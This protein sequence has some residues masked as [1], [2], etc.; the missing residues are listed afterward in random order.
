MKFCLALLILGATISLA[1]AQTAPQPATGDAITVS[2]GLSPISLP[3]AP[4]SIAG[5]ETDVVLPFTTNN[6][7][8]ETS[9]VSSSYSFVG[10][11]YQRIFPQ[12]GT[13]LNNVSALNFLNS[14]IGLTASVGVVFVNGE[15]HWGTTAGVFWMQNINS[16]WA[17]TFDAEAV[18]F[19]Y[20]ANSAWTWKFAAG[21]NLKF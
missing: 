17:T 10:G 2:F 6:W 12:I 5:A 15:K 7:I 19:P 13:Y 9:I 4:S 8:G 21:P 16:T 14:D 11:K 18:R 3:D 1:S 20:V